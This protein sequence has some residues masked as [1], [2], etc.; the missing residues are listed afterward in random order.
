M[1]TC[2]FCGTTNKIVH[3]GVDAML[4]ECMDRIG[5]ICYDCANSNLEK[6]KED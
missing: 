3:S 4:L 5:S 2:V 6:S 1:S